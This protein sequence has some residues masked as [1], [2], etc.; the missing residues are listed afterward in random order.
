M[1]PRILLPVFILLVLVVTVFSLDRKSANTGIY[2]DK[3]WKFHAGDNRSWASRD[4]DDNAWQSIDPTRDIHQLLPV[5][6]STSGWLRLK[7]PAN[8]LS[9]NTSYAIVIQQSIGAEYY[10]DGQLIYKFGT[11]NEESKNVKANDPLSEPVV[12]PATANFDQTLAVRFAVQP[13]TRYSTIFETTNPLL[14]I[15]IVPTNEAIKNYKSLSGKLHGFEFFLI[16]ISALFFILH[17]SLFILYPEQKAN[18][19]FAI[20]GFCSI[21]AYTLRLSLF[22]YNHSV[23]AKFYM[24]NVGFIF[25]TLSNLLILLSLQKNL[26][27]KADLVLKSLIGLTILSFFINA[28]VYEYGWRLGGVVVQLLIMFNVARIAFRSWQE[29]KRGAWIIV[30]GSFSTLVFFAIFAAQGS[31]SGAS[32]TQDLS[33]ARLLAYIFFTLSIVVT[34]SIFLAMDFAFTN[35][36]LRQKITEMQKLAEKNLLQEKEKQEILS[37][38]NEKLEI[39]VKQRTEELQQSLSD[40]RLTQAQ[41]VHREK[42]AS[43]GELTAGIAHEIQ[44]PLNFVNNFSDVNRELIEELKSEKSKV[45]NERDDDLENQ[46]WSD[47]EQNLEK[48]H[49]HGK[50][51]DA[52]V[53][54]MLQHSRSSAGQKEPIDINSLADEYLRLAYHGL[55]AKDKTFNAIARTDFDNSIE[56]VNVVPQ[57]IGRVIFNLINNAFYAVSEKQKNDLNGYEPAV[58]VSTNKIRDKIEIKVQD[59]GNGIPQK[60]L[61]KIFQPFFTTKPTGQG[62]GL[63]LSLAYDIITKGHGGELKVETKEGEGS[64]FIITIPNSLNN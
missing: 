47:I 12:F 50:R 63:G 15:H 4:H 8:T 24:A 59:N 48:I 58:T 36:V 44:N 46:L 28:F 5:I 25:I 34:T 14:S 18:L 60:V 13:G 45:K 51:A 61:D 22:L 64:A 27:R 41:L 19:Y 20:G 53:K 56:M 55:R 62:T 21:V 35:R 7:I 11:I 3:G 10:L 38:M 23:D 30:A 6:N 37:S 42:M 33:I 17:L 54:G 40:L 29:K 31:F 2:L 1:S 43:L 9:A 16:G 52:I 49:H 39:K 26:G 32:F 57:E